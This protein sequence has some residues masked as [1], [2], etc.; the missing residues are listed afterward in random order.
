MFLMLTTSGRT[1]FNRK[2]K[3]GKTI[4]EGMDL[5]RSLYISDDKHGR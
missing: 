4:G 5:L 3:D 1:L 2:W